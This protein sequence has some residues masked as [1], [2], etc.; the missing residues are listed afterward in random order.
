M[1]EK[2]REKGEEDS[3]GK[4]SISADGRRA[5]NCKA[6]TGCRLYKDQLVWMVSNFSVG[7]Y[8]LLG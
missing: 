6:F 2:K 7:F 4:I 3:L 8:G 5:R 1:G